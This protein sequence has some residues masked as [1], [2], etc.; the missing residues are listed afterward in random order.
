MK[1]RTNKKQKKE[2]LTKKTLY[3]KSP[4]FLILIR[5]LVLLGIILSL[6]II[7][8]IMTPLTI[9]PVDFLLKIFVKVILTISDDLYPLFILGDKTII[10]IV[11]ACIAGSAYLALLILNLTVPMENRKRIYSIVLSVLMLLFLNILRISFFSL[12]YYYD[13]PFTDFT[14]KFFWYGLSTIFVVGLWFFIVNIF[15]IKGIPVYSDIKFVY[16]QIRNKT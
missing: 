15:K 1:K 14:H 13:M 3:A 11:P 6:S 9:Y 8:L 16:S 12:L 10:E 2:S 5:Y 7:Y 4:V